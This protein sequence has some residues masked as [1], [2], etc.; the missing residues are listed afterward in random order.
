MA[1]N[2][3]KEEAAFDGKAVARK[4]P[5]RPGV[6]LMK[7]GAGRVIYVG[8]ASGRHTL[9]QTQ[10]NALLV[11][12]ASERQQVVRLKGGDP[13]IFGRGGEEALVLARRGI[14]FEVVPG[15]T[16]ASG[17]ATTR[18][19]TSARS[20]GCAPRSRRTRGCH[21]RRGVRHER[22]AHARCRPGPPPG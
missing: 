5:T 4:L 12:L 16:A 7:D 6:Y 18:R 9:S 11:E 20:T 22:A 17:C 19:R 13:F 15:I 14:A 10:I 2:K 1:E 8:K 21:C 3:G